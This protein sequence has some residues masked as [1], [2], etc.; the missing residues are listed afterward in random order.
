[1]HLQGGDTVTAFLF[2]VGPKGPWIQTDLGRVDVTGE[3]LAEA[4]KEHGIKLVPP[5]SKPFPDGFAR[6]QGRCP[7]CRMSALFL[8]DGGYITCG[9][10]QCTDPCAANELLEQP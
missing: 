4:C 3:E 1:M 5:E 8:G 2:G 7:A 9:N 6:V 10:L